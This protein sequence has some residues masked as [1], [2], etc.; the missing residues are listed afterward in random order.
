MDQPI[1]TET[2]LRD[3][4]QAAGTDNAKQVLSNADLF[5]FVLG[6]FNHTVKMASGK[7]T[8]LALGFASKTLSTAKVAGKAVGS[9]NLQVGSVAAQIIITTASLVS[10][11]GKTPSMAVAALADL[12]ASGLTSTVAFAA[13]GT[14]IGT[15]IF[16]GSVAQLLLSGYQVHQACLVKAR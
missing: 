15:V 2:A 12:A 14:G 4:L 16:A 1:S 5:A 11:A 6:M 10:V 3:G 7:G 9:T 8:D 13:V